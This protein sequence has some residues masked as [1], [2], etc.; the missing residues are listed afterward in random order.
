MRLAVSSLSKSVNRKA[1]NSHVLRR[2]SKIVFK[3]VLGSE[4]IPKLVKWITRLA[5][6][7]PL[8]AGSYGTYLGAN[9]RAELTEA[10]IRMEIIGP[11]GA[12]Y[13]LVEAFKINGSD[14]NNSLPAGLTI[15]FDKFQIPTEVRIS[16]DPK[17][18]VNNLSLRPGSVVP[19]KNTFIEGGVFENIVAGE[20]IITPD[21]NQVMRFKFRPSGNSQEQAKHVVVFANGFN[22]SLILN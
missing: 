2:A 4:R 13:R 7:I 6:P 22:G 14:V 11:H 5:L 12:D 9:H 18:F 16:S 1:L 17:D 10:N 19:L 3:P 21:N 15:A 8:L 20:R